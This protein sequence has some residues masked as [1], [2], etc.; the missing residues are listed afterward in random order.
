MVK[1][2]FLWLIFALPILG[3]TTQMG[4][5]N[6]QTSMTSAD[7]ASFGRIT[8]YETQSI[9][10]VLINPASLGGISFNQMT[11]ST[12]QLSSQFDY[13]HF[14]FV[15][16]Y[17]DLVVGISYGTNITSGFIE[18]DISNGVIY[19][20]G[21]FSSGF[22]VLHLSMGQKINEGFFFIDHFNYGFGLS[23]LTQ[24]IGS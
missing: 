15:I 5:V 6:I 2:L 18:T 24:V 19:D 20:I 23:M 7:I 10:N 11:V 16:P 3:Q 12:Y 13:R 9:G 21:S 8:P 17:G 22:D 14:N 1:Y 4:A